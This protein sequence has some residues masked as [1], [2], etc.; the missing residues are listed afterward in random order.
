MRVGI[1][2]GAFNPPHIG[3]LVCAQEA[4]AHLALDTLVWVPMGQPPHREIEDDPGRE[5]RYTMCEYATSADERFSL[6][7]FE[8]DREGPSY[9]VDTLRAVAESTPGAELFVI[10]GA[11][12]AAAL[13][14]WH[15]PE[16]VLSLATVAAVARA[17]RTREMV[18]DA[19]SSLAGGDRVVFFD[20]PRIDVSSTLVRSRA[21]A[22]QPIRYLVP[23]KVANY[24]GAQ[25][26]YGSSQPVGAER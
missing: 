19:V 26:L 13:P 11:D 22:G 4:H 21:R 14:T 15:E 2:G 5:A 18:V 24:I 12:Q 16:E 3:H 6:S 8:I 23:D 10:L 7:R 9:T 1:F 17:E 25:S 20:M